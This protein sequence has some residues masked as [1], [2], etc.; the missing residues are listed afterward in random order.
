[1]LSLPAM[2]GRPSHRHATWFSKNMAMPLEYLQL[3]YG[4]S[5]GMDFLPFISGSMT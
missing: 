1:M 3:A 5:H 2:A 4:Q